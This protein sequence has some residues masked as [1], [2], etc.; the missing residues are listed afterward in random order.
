MHSLIQISTL[1]GLHNV[2]YDGLC[3]I[4]IQKS[5]KTVLTHVFFFIIINKINRFPLCLLVS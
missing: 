5:V 3:L 4:F 2:N 1:D